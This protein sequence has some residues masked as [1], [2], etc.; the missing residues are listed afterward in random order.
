MVRAPGPDLRAVTTGTLARA[1]L[2]PQGMNRVVAGLG[3]E[4]I[5]VGQAAMTCEG[6]I[7]YSV[8]TVF[9]YPTLAEAYKMAA[10]E[11]LDKL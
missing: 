9:T 6:T 5:H 1:I 2:P 8:N 4:I 3:A 7:E 11:G 10:F